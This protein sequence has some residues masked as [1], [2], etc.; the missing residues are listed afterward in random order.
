MEYIG[1]LDDTSALFLMIHDT[2]PMIHRLDPL[3]YHLYHPTMTINLRDLD[4]ETV[5][6]FRVL[7]AEYGVSMKEALCRT[8]RRAVVRHMIPA[9]VQEEDYEIGKKKRAGMLAE[10]EAVI[11]GSAENLEEEK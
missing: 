9:D 8:M 6:G 1:G 10:R 11:M 7:C 3:P 4:E 2:S 5:D